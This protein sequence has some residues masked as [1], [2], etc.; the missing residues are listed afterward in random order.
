MMRRWMMRVVVV[1]LSLVTVAC[2]LPL[3]HTATADQASPATASTIGSGLRLTLTLA[4]SISPRNA[5]V[6]ATVE[7]DNLTDHDVGYVL[8]TAPRGC[9]PPADQYPIVRSVGADG[10]VYPPAMPPGLLAWGC[11]PG[12]YGHYRP[13]ETRTYT[14]PVVLDTNRVRATLQVENADYT[15]SAPMEAELRVRL[16]HEAAPAVSIQEKGSNLIA[17]I[18]AGR[19]MPSP[20]YY[21]DKV[22]C[23]A[24]PQSF[25]VSYRN[26]WTA[27][28]GTTLRSGYYSPCAPPDHWYLM[29][30]WLNHPI[31]IIHYH[32]SQSHSPPTP[33]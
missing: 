29:V 6:Q 3:S 5:L 20:L 21:M 14:I 30:G 22:S 17:T 9:L 28:S 12:A 15:G 25:L 8:G 18:G 1:G 27:H 11:L 4:R 2:P 24:G 13:N 16:T 26:A 33:P 32:R 19:T 10:T 31:A 7:V 23:G